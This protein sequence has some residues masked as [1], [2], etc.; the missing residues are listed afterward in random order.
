M[1]TNQS[2]MFYVSSP[3]AGVKKNRFY[4]YV[5]HYGFFPGIVS[6]MKNA[7]DA[8]VTMDMVDA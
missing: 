5:H 4:C 3:H 2:A 6:E 8:F 1:S 7:H